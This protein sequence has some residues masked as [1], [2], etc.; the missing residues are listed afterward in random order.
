ML[1]AGPLDRGQQGRL[2]ST[3]DGISS[4]STA[5][6]PA[7]KIWSVRRYILTNQDT[8]REKKSAIMFLPV[9]APCYASWLRSDHYS[10]GR[11][12]RERSESA[13]KRHPDCGAYMLPRGN[14]TR[15]LRA[16]K[17][18]ITVHDDLHLLNL[19]QPKLA[20]CDN[21]RRL[22]SSGLT[23]ESCFTT[24][25]STCQWRLPSVVLRIAISQQL[26][27]AGPLLRR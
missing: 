21:E 13:M 4:A 16:V 27:A 19:P 17:R 5:R 15:S 25:V 10:Q 1:T 14:G 11:W 24:T 12:E 18:C 9:R 26:W 7:Y 2:L 3:A 20:V 22:C 8:L 23:V 6:G